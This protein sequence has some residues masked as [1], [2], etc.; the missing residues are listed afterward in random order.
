MSIFDTPVWV[1]LLLSWGVH[2]LRFLLEL[3]F[4]T[5]KVLILGVVRGALPLA[6]FNTN[7]LSLR[8]SCVQGHH[9]WGGAAVK[10]LGSYQ[11]HNAY[12]GLSIYKYKGS[13]VV[14][15]AQRTPRLDGDSE[16]THRHDVHILA[17]ARVRTQF[18][19]VVLGD[20]RGMAAVG[21]SERYATT[22]IEKPGWGCDP[23]VWGFLLRSLKE[24]RE[25]APSR[26]LRGLPAGRLFLLVGPPGVGKTSLAVH[27][28]VAERLQ[29]FAAH[30]DSSTP[31]VPG[32]KPSWTGAFSVYA[33]G[34]TFLSNGDDRPIPE[35]ETVINTVDD[36][37][38]L[39]GEIKGGSPQMRRALDQLD[40]ALNMNVMLIATANS[41]EGLDPA[42]LS[43]LQVIQ[44]GLPRLRQVSEIIQSYTGES[45][46]ACTLAAEGLMP[47]RDL[48]DLRRALDTNGAQTQGLRAAY[49]DALRLRKETDKAA[50]P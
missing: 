12:E 40:A 21:S 15:I 38:R 28:A 3:A 48:R 36:I 49:D 42:F 37:D 10:E 43:R 6:S 2:V 4:P 16:N 23:L 1:A 32:E 31:V 46:E 9:V 8:L 24:I 50:G 11:G 13:W 22:Y 34:L 7:S 41:I 33:G 27:L 44:M 19:R 47:V 20:V 39:L 30:T 25:N 5:L 35:T 29:I 26:I 18:L 14:V 17:P 45:M